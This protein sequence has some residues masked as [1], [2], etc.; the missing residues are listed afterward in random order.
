LRRGAVGTSFGLQEALRCVKDTRS[1]W[2]RHP[3]RCWGQW[4]DHTDM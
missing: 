1:G 2:W 4:I 3:G